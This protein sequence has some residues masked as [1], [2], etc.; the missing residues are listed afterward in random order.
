MFI[1]I[2]LSTWDSWIFGFFT[3]LFFIYYIDLNCFIDSEKKIWH[4]PSIMTTTITSFINF[5]KKKLKMCAWK[6]TK[7]VSAYFSILNKLWTILPD[8]PTCHHFM[9][10][11]NFRTKRK[12][13]YFNSFKLFLFYIF[14][15]KFH[16]CFFDDVFVF[17]RYGGCQ[18]S[19]VIPWSC[20]NYF[21][22]E[23][24]HKEKAKH[25]QEISTQIRKQRTK[26]NQLPRKKH[27][28]FQFK[29]I[30]HFSD[31]KLT[32]HAYLFVQNFCPVLNT[33]NI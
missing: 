9:F 17:V 27:S 16:S 15:K 10:L 20:L 30:K 31:E 26:N 3:K 7:R 8:W 11:Y 2:Y 12:Y 23:E 21:H 22:Q 6:N 14:P 33:K 19:I 25:K 24:N 4:D 18:E 28:N 1:Y 5:I 32:R 13:Y 29:W